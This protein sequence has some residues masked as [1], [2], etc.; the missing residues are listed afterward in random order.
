M[1][2]QLISAGDV[3]A[4]SALDPDGREAQIVDEAERAVFEMLER[5]ARGKIGFRTVKSIFAPGGQPN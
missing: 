3:I 1:L 5:G 2:R 4:R